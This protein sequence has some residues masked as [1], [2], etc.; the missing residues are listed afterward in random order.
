LS[1]IEGLTRKTEALRCLLHGEVVAANTTQHFVFHLQ[2]VVRIE[3][4]AVGEAF[5]GHPVGPGIEGAR[6]A[7]HLALRGGLHVSIQLC[8]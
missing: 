2:E 4:V 1:L 8:P 6:P 7:E 3:E 5:V